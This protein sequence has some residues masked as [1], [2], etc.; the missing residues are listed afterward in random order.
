MNKKQREE[1]EKVLI[2]VL[3][4]KVAEMMTEENKTFSEL[5]EEKLS[6]CARKLVERFF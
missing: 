1:R 4:E 6:E 5:D 3:R 2:K